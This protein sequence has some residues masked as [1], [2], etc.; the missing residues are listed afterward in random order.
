MFLPV[1]IVELIRKHIGKNIYVISCIGG[2]PA[3]HD[4]VLNGISSKGLSLK[5]SG[6]YKDILNIDLD[7]NDKVLHVLDRKNHD[8]MHNH[9]VLNMGEKLRLEMYKDKVMSS[10]KKYYKQRIF[11][12]YKQEGKMAFASG[13]FE[14]LG[15]QGLLLRN[16]HEPGDHLRV[17]YTNILFIYGNHCDHLV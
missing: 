4:G 11:I 5:I 13:N 1:N 7:K 3:L 10:I 16:V 14:D 8:L 17:A 12:F 6:L 2:K 15:I 9:L